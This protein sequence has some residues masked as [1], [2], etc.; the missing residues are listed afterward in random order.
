VLLVDCSRTSDDTMHQA[1]EV[2]AAPVGT[3]QV[4]A[5]ALNATRK[6]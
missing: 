1:I 3:G 2:S 6:T 4:S 5:I